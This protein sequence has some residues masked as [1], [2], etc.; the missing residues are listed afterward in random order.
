[1][2]TID[3]RVAVLLDKVPPDIRH[4]PAYKN[5]ESRDMFCLGEYLLSRGG[6]GGVQY[7]GRHATLSRPTP[8]P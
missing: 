3:I 4:L 2:S 6:G 7:W 8:Q 5:F 1:M